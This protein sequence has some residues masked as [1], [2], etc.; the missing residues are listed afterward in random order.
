[1]NSKI[2]AWQ[3]WLDSLATSGG[4][5]LTLSFWSI[6]T[7]ALWIYVEIKIKDPSVNTATFGVFTGFT[8][9]LLQ[10]QKGNSSRQQMADRIETA[11]S[12]QQV[13][14]SAQAAA[15]A[16]PAPPQGQQIP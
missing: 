12:S 8:G 13:Q 11:T 5:I 6:V 16:S 15:Q 14:A 2:K 1:M 4:N 9:S 10:A 3:D 7:G